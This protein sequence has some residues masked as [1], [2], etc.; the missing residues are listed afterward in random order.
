MNKHGILHLSNLL[1]V[2]MLLQLA[3]LLFG[4][5]E[6]TTTLSRSS[7]TLRETKSDSEPSVLKVEAGVFFLDQS[8]Y[9][10][11]PLS[12]FGLTNDRTIEA[13][14]SSCECVFPTVIR[15]QAS[16]GTSKE[17]IRLD[18]L[19]ERQS[20]SNARPVSLEVEVTVLLDNQEKRAIVLT[21]LHTSYW[22]DAKT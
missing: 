21:F 12:Q 20:S 10:C 17:A 11:I 18:I 6:V 2:A 14:T 7:T 9:L 4:C 16:Q 3:V 15:Y 13:V 8:S 1:I 19:K 22:E 5:Q